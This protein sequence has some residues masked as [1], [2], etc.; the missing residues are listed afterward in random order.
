MLFVSD[1]VRCICNC[2]CDAIVC[3]GGC[4]IV[5]G[6]CAGGDRASFIAVCNVCAGGDRVCC[7]LVGDFGVIDGRA[8]CGDLVAGGAV[9]SRGC[10]GAIGSV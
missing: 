5:W 10:C 4:F 9:G 3:L 1:S 6:V 8:S 2:G 7:V